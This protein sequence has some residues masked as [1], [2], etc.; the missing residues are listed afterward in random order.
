M[1]EYETLLVDVDDVG[2][3]T[4]TLN[5]PDK[6]NTFNLAMDKEFFEALHALDADDNVRAIVVTGAGRAFSAGVDMSEGNPFDQ[7]AHAAHDEALGTSSDTID[8]RT[9]LWRLPTPIIGA[10]NGA[11]V[12]AGLT[13]ATMFDIN[14]VNEEAKLGFVFTRRGIL[15][16][17]AIHWTLPKLVGLQRALELLMSGRMFLGTDAAEYGL[18]LEAVPADDVVARAQEVARDIAVNAGPTVVGL[19]KQLTHHYLGE[20][21]RGGAMQQETRL[22]WWSGTQPDAMEGVMS[23][24]EKRTPEW[25]GTKHPDLPESL[26]LR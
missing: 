11:A 16:D 18:A 14:I 23:F 10:I 15:P 1:Y 19:T 8:A 21:S 25:K 20:P 2:V 3:A 24:M 6:M 26:D 7:D 4:V 13:V 22:V 9:A 17:A 12:G 5:R